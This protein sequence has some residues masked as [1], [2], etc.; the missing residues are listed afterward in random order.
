MFKFCYREHYMKG[1]SIVLG[2]GEKSVPTESHEQNGFGKVG[3]VAEVGVE[4]VGGGRLK[5]AIEGEWT[6]S[7][8]CFSFAQPAV[9]LTRSGGRNKVQ[10]L[11]DMMFDVH[12]DAKGF[13]GTWKKLET[14]RAQFLKEP[15]TH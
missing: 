10:K 6:V 8:Y 5:V 9:R 3:E 13:V 2:K 14:V 4:S 15:M 11:M 12:F 1:D 7:D